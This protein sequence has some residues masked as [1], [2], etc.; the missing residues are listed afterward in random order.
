M[1]SRSSSSSH[2]LMRNLKMAPRFIASVRECISAEPE[3]NKEG[4]IN[5]DAIQANFHLFA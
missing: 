3:S 1:L 4:E 5:T 2:G